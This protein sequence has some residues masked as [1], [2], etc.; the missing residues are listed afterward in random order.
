MFELLCFVVCFRDFTLFVIFLHD[1]SQNE[2]LAHMFQPFPFCLAWTLRCVWILATA[3]NQKLSW[4]SRSKSTW[5]N[6]SLSVWDQKLSVHAG[7]FWGEICIW[8]SISISI[9][10][11]W[12]KEVPCITLQEGA[13]KQLIELSVPMFDI[14]AAQTG[15]GT[16]RK[17]QC[18]RC[19]HGSQVEHRCDGTG[20]LSCLIL[21]RYSGWYPFDNLENTLNNHRSTRGQCWHDQFPQPWSCEKSWGPADTWKGKG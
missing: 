21:N 16:H 3:R 9:C 6:N 10:T 17:V 2:Q 5:S 19:R 4:L 7:L 1:I 18:S 20:F 15:R 11:R 8:S 14:K 13:Q 12:K